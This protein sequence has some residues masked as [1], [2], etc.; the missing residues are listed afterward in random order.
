MSINNGVWHDAVLDPPGDHMDGVKVLVV[1]GSA[2]HMEIDTG[3]HWNSTPEWTLT[4]TIQPVLYW[5][6]LPKMPG[7]GERK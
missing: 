2:E 5:M 1:K 7:E 4:C 6:P 3:R